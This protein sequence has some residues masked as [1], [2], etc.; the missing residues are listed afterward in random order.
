MPGL[1]ELNFK[2]ASNVHVMLT[3]PSHSQISLAVWLRSLAVFLSQ[4]ALRYPPKKTEERTI[5]IYLLQY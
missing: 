4:D 1:H 5:K 3:F 2:T